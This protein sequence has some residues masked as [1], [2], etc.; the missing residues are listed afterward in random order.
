MA[1]I[2]CYN[3]KKATPVVAPRYRCKFCN[4]PL[5]KYVES[6]NT[7]PDEVI[8]DNPELKEREL[9]PVI[10]VIPIEPEKVES[11]LQENK[12]A[13][14]GIQNLLSKLRP[15]EKVEKAST[16]A[17]IIKQN[18]NPA[19]AGKIVAGWLVV[20]TENKLPVTYDLYE[21]DNVI[22]R[23]DGAHQIDIRIEDDDY[24]SR[25][26]AFI[27]VHKDY[28]H[29]FRYE[30]HD[31]G[32]MSR[33]KVSTNGTYINGIEERL[34]KEKTV[35]L[36]DGD[37]IQVGTTKLVFKSINDTDDHISAFSSVANSNFTETVA[38]RL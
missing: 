28:L 23:P 38:I 31:N 13:L 9:Q 35:F 24:V 36:R 3:C 16:G 30:L 20:H 37:T 34:P 18:H 12:N 19:K 4:Y 29:R 5:N 11:V 32:A 1:K 6:E 7:A 25:F 8:I 14:D 10:P 33:G 15:D 21:G 2:Q 17:V 22:G 26:H 27:H